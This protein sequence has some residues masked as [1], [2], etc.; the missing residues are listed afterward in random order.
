MKAWRLIFVDSLSIYA[1]K[2]NITFSVFDGK[3][4]PGFNYRVR[5]VAHTDIEDQEDSAHALSAPVDFTMT[6]PREFYRLLGV[7]CTYLAHTTCNAMML[8]L[9]CHLAFMVPVP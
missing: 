2:R 4:T 3:W 1:G 9:L 8:P 5:I 7:W 6:V